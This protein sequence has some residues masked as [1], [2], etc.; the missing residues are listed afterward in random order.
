MLG[1]PFLLVGGLG[2]FFIMTDLML[3]GF[4]FAFY[5]LVVIFASYVS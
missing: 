4:F 3:L 5:C 2:S 1:R